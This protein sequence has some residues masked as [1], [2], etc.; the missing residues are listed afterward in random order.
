[1]ARPKVWKY[2]T[3]G[4]IYKT[5]VHLKE[6]CDNKNGRQAVD[7]FSRGICYS[8]EWKSFDIFYE[9]MASSWKQGL[10]LDRID[11]DGN[12]SKENCRWA[13]RKTQ[14]NNTRRNRYIT[15]NGVTKTLSEWCEHSSL[16]SSTIRQRYYVYKWS[17]EKSLGFNN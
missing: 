3:D 6:R 8:D 2:P 17:I 1:M 10:T 14:N 16:K 4:P 7:Y 11:N 5:W 12:Y 9:D 13:D 15:I